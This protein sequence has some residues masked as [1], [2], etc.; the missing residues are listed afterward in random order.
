MSSVLEDILEQMAASRA[1]SER[2][3]ASEAQTV[4]AAGTALIAALRSGGKLLTFGN[5]GSAADAQHLANEL[6]NRFETER[7][8]LAAIALT[9]DSSNL[10]A[11][12]NDYAW[13]R[14]FARQIEALGTAGDVALGITTSGRSPNVLRALETAKERGLVRIGFL[15]G[16]GGPAR[17]LCEHAIIVPHDRTA[18]VQEVH[19]QVLHAVCSM[20]DA[21]LS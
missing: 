8:G 18:R 5:G 14:V 10:T 17:E 1:L 7:R 2:F 6:V 21:A 9:T 3:W 20:V 4:E 11:I 12:S 13:D 15:G 16:D 19:L